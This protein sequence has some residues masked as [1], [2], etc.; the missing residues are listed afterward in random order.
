[1]CNRELKLNFESFENFNIKG[2]CWRSFKKILV[3]IF[4]L[5]RLNIIGINALER[6]VWQLTSVIAQNLLCRNQWHQLARNKMSIHIIKCI[7]KQR[8]TVLTPKWSVFYTILV[9][10]RLHDSWGDE[11]KCIACCLIVAWVKVV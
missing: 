3:F 7:S 10:I 2:L 5:T 4:Q 11:Q 9:R 1:M 6:L 8:Q